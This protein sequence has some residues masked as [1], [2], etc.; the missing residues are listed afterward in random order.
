[1][2]TSHW[3]SYYPRLT[4][5]KLKPRKIKLHCPSNVIVDGT[6]RI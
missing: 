4:V 2:L 6:A 5:R 3:S 1:M